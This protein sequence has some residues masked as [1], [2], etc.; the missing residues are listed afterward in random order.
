[1]RT[2]LLTSINSRSRTGVLQNITSFRL[3]VG[4]EVIT[5][6]QLFTL[7]TVSLSFSRTWYTKYHL[8]YMTMR[9]F[10]FRFLIADVCHM[11]TYTGESWIGIANFN[12]KLWHP[13]LGVWA[14]RHSMQTLLSN[15]FSLLPSLSYLALY[16]SYL[17]HMLWKQTLSL[18]SLLPSPDSHYTYYLWI[19]CCWNK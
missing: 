19:T 8:P 1:M 16:L 17:N 10:L 5:L 14:P 3:Q 2:W 15:F 6:N 9:L 4:C 7:I 11:Y 12:T 18:F 13:E